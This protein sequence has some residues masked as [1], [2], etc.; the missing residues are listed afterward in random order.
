[1]SEPEMNK[2]TRQ[3]IID[4]SIHLF[5]LK[6]YNGASTREIAKIAK[7]NIASLNYHFRSKQNLLQEVSAFVIEEFDHKLTKAAQKDAK[8]AA[9][10]AVLVFDLLLEDEV[11]CLNH[12]KLYLDA[13]NSPKELDP[14][15]MGFK[16]LTHFLDKELS[17]KVPLDEKLWLT[18]IIMS[19][20]SHMSVMNSSALGKKYIEKHMPERQKTVAD[21]L[22]RLVET[23]IRDLNVRYQ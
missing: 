13:E 22:R 23:I 3:R 21:Y 7:V 17:A 1:M 18:N 14:H 12:F 10:F 5:G 20:I 16:Q 4:A 19:Y 9:E 6:G 15:P 2:D 11:R 8:S